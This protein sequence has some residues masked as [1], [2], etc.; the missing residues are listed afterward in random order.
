VGALQESAAL[1]VQLTLGGG[2]AQSSKSRLNEIRS[3]LASGVSAFLLP[4]PICN[5]TE[6]LAALLE[7]SALWVAISQASPEAHLLSVSA[8]H[9]DIARRMTAR[10]IELGHRRVAFIAGDP[11]SKGGAERYRGHLAALEEAGLKPG[12]LEQG[13]FTFE[14]GLTAAERLLSRGRQCTAIVACNDDMAAATISVAHR[15]GMHVPDDLTVVGFD[16]TPI[17][18]IVTPPITTARQPIAEMARTAIGLL[19]QAKTSRQ[20]RET[21]A[22]HEVFHCTLIERESSAPPRSPH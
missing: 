4:P 6:V 9:F 22:K 3:L 10:L 18:T 16:D 19:E 14:S 11:S 21:L 15:H 20:A 17:S 2:G 13:Y 5:S 12:Q 1:G 8:D 7:A